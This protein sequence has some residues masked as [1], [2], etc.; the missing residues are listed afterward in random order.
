VRLTV[1]VVDDRPAVVSVEV[2]SAG[3]PENIEPITTAAVRIPLDTLMKERL[4]DARA[5]KARALSSPKGR[6]FSNWNARGV[7]ALRAVLDTPERGRGGRP[8]KY[9]DDH[10]EGVALIYKRALQD[11]LNPTAEVRRVKSSG[12]GSPISL[13]TAAKWVARARAL[14]YLP[15]TEQGRAKAFTE[16]NEP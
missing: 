6:A 7:E 16:G 1:A 5:E 15:P 8:R 9:D 12:L 11:G 10:F 14:G 3:D 13:S 2:S 4:E